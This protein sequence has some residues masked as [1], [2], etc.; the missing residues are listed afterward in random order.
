[1][2]AKDPMPGVGEG[3]VRRGPNSCPAAAEQRLDVRFVAHIARWADDVRPEVVRPR[4][5]RVAVDVADHHAC[6]LGD[7]ATHRG[8]A[9]P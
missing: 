1:M 4:G 7:E 2:G 3:D 5:G 6:T 8:E 9:D